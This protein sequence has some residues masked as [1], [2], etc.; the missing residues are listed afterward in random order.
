MGLFTDGLVSS[1]EDLTANDSQLLDVANT[2]GIDVCRK[3]ALAQDDVGV[4]LAVLLSRLLFAD[5]AFWVAA[6]PDLKSVVVTPPLKL[7]HTYLSLE[8]VYRDAYNS[9]LNDR[10]AGKRDQFHQMTEWARE[11]LIQTGIGIAALPIAMAVTPRVM[12]I[13]GAL[14]DGTYYVTM[15]WMNL[16]GEEG[17]SAVP[18][19]IAI[20]GS[21]LQVQPGPQPENAT[22][23]NVYIGNDG[24]NMV[25]QNETPIAAGELWQQLPAL[26]TAGR[27]PGNGQAPTYLKPISRVIQRG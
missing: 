18:A 3:L 27:A 17:A 23:W 15:A 20:T 14:P 26:A 1:V 25:L 19:V 13:S 21:T 22:G 5:Q 16:R 2:E 8:M 10:Y 11:K 24:E 4:E 7:W 12:P 6:A 9:Q